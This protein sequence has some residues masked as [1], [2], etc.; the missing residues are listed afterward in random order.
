MQVRIRATDLA[1]LTVEQALTLPVVE[2]KLRINEFL[3]GNLT[4]LR[5]ENRQPQDWIE[6]YNEQA[7]AIDLTGWYLTDN[8]DNLTK[9]RF[10]TRTIGPNGY[11]II[12]AD[13]T[14]TPPGPTG[15]LHAELLTRPRR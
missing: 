6:L 13:S 10:P 1:G 4:G 3:A 9:W 14:A 7:Q 5:D 15:T 2:P 8:R 12:F 11:L